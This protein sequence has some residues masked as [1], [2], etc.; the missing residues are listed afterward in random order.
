MEVISP[1]RAMNIE[2]HLEQASVWLS[3]CEKGANTT[4]LSYA[5]FELRLAT[6]RLA[7]QYWSSLH[8]VLQQLMEAEQCLCTATI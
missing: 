8:H 4:F 5:A 2:H 1:V 7:L 6:E 3:S